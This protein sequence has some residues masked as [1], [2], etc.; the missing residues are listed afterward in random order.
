MRID[1]RL[2]LLLAAALLSAC[3]SQPSPAPDTT[4]TPDATAVPVSTAT[5][6][7][8]ATATPE[9]VIFTI[10][11]P[12]IVDTLDPAN[13]AEP[14][15][16]LITRH[17]YDGLTRLS[18]GGTDVEPALA[19][20]WDVSA[21]ATV[22]TFTLRS[23]VTFSTGAVF[24]STAAKANLD[25]WLS[26]NPSGAYPY[27]PA[28]W[29]GF[30]DQVDSTG[31]PLSNVQNVTAP[32]P[33]TL[34]VQLRRPDS[35]LPATLAMPAFAMV[36]PTAWSTVGFGTAGAPSAG[37]GAFVLSA[38]SQPDLVEL[39][40]NANAWSDSA[41]VDGLRFKVVAD[42]TQRVMA[43]QVDEVDALAG[44]PV[45][46]ASIA[47][48]WPVRVVVEP[49]Q[50]VL[51]LGFNQA[52]RP[53]STPA[54][55]LAVGLGLDRAALAQAAGGNAM[56]RA[57]FLATD[58]PGA[59]QMEQARTAWAECVAQQDAPIAT[60]IALYVPAIPRPYL[61]DPGAFASA[62]Q[63]QL[64]EIGIE[65]R[66]VSTDWS[67]QWLPD[68]QAGR[69]DLFVL[70]IGSL[71]GDP[72]SLLCPLLCGS[73]AAL[74][75]G[76]DGL[77]IAPDAELAGLLAQAQATGDIAQR[78]AL[79]QQTDTIIA[80]R[81]PV[82]ALSSPRTSWAIRSEWQGEVIGPLDAWFGAVN[83]SAP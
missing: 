61:A 4:P 48:A 17:L 68:V 15:A 72:G 54:C 52:R 2:S 51:Y 76:R 28:L 3:G 73:N 1:P 74:M 42:D 71:N 32:A 83:R 26:G 69:A 34:T 63:A 66:L 7:P 35:G 39:A 79:Y 53:W 23:G 46:E 11:L 5:P 56:P 22:Y 80:E 30:A 70:G 36:D 77:P 64:T 81:L 40:R 20:R 60:P 41:T 59:A 58:E 21:D 38:W 8:T 31:A 33:D 18:P 50:Q 65:T 49:P 55:R 25:R 16:L 6:E 62:L 14:A 29:G 43:L 19:E 82:L 44:L 10:G 9:P 12:G 37:T 67:T 57:M 24:D 75:T 45:S 47:D 13:A 78:L 27:V